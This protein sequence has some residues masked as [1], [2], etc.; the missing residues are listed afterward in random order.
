M[1]RPWLPKKEPMT[2]KIAPMKARRATV[3]RLLRIMW[4]HLAGGTRPLHGMSSILSPSPTQPVGAG[5]RL[6]MVRRA[7]L[8]PRGRTGFLRHGDHPRQPRAARALPQGVVGTGWKRPAV[9]RRQPA[10]GASRRAVAADR[11]R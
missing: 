3:L 8:G 2:I 11:E 5:S 1:K 6:R 9:D 4:F 7:A 10:A